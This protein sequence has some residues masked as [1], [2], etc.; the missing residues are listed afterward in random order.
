MSTKVEKSNEFPMEERE[1]E[2]PRGMLFAQK[3]CMTES[4][5][6]TVEPAA[7]EKP[8][9]VKLPAWAHLVCGWPLVMVAFG[10][11]IGG[12]LGGAAYGVNLWIFK[13]RL[14]LAAKV[15]LNVFAGMAA[16]VFWALIASAI[17]SKHR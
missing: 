7:S 15:A 8:E 14:P 10:G 17:H 6:M 5:N 16:F 3:N 12:G 1:S 9:S 11:A 4:E 13:S 2:P